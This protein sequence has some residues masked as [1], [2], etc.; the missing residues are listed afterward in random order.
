[1]A[2]SKEEGHTKR[3]LAKA[4]I[5][6]IENARDLSFVSAIDFRVWAQ[7]NEMLEWADM[8]LD[9]GTTECICPEVS[10]VIK[11]PMYGDVI[12]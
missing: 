3:C 7:N 5:C 11:D 8:Y 12:Q 2:R 9:E 1:M 6:A 4:L 10:E